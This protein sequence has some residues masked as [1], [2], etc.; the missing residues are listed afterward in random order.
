MSRWIDVDTLVS[1]SQVAEMY[2]VRRSTVSMWRTRNED[3]PEAI[4]IAGHEFYVKA[5]ITAWWERHS[6]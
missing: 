1:P 5:D 3:F 2:M 6:K 4:T